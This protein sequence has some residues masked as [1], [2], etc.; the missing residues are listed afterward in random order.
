MKT[1]YDVRGYLLD[2][3]TIKLDEPLPRESGDVRVVVEFIEGG[4]NKFSRRKMRGSLK[5]EIIIAGDFNE[6]LECMGEYML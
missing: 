6:P 3:Q 4:S 2:G 5:G 1:A